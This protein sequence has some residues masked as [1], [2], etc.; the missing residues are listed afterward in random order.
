LA[1]L[2]GDID[3]ASIQHKPTGRSFEL[4]AD[5]L[6]GSSSRCDLTLR[7]DSV[8][9]AHASIFWVDGCWYV[10][11]RN[12][13]NGTW[14]DGECLSSTQRRL[15]V[16]SV[17]RFGARGVEEWEVIHLGPPLTASAVQPTARLER[18][19]GQSA[20]FI[21]SNVSLQV[22]AGTAIHALKWRAPY[23]TLL[24][25]GTE[26]I[27][28]RR[29]GRSAQDEGWLDR[30]MLAERLRDRDLNQDIFRIRQDFHALSLFDDADD[31]V[32]DQREDGKIRLGMYHVRVE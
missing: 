8:S 24:A 14:I 28:D 17:L 32:E 7:H 29:A 22:T 5:T 2:V 16:G 1:A 20:L 6:I 19:V 4:A 23:V 27:H 10:E 25:L 3:M 21:R 18:H 9:R 11:D 15:D 13:K 31:V 26:R 30:R 12:S